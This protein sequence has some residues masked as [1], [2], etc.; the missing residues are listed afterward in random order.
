MGRHTKRA[1]DNLLKIVIPHSR[2]RPLEIEQL[3][4]TSLLSLL[5]ETLCVLAFVIW[6]SPRWARDNL[7]WRIAP[8]WE[9]PPRLSRKIECRSL[10]RVRTSSGESIRQGRH[11]VVTIKLV[12]P[13]TSWSNAVCIML[14]FLLSLSSKKPESSKIIWNGAHCT[15]RTLD[16]SFLACTGPLDKSERTAYISIQWRV[17]LCIIRRQE[18]CISL[19]IYVL[20]Q[21]TDK[22]A[23]TTL[24]KSLHSALSVPGAK[25]AVR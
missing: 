22:H 15:H 18:V 5:V 20:E 7:C 23:S 4:L 19:T 9:R 17:H 16:E 1:L 10:Q 8:L 24:E 21:C 13:W 6:S 14:N 12:K 25:F 3:M 2:C 11:P